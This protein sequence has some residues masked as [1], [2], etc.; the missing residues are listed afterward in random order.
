M[1]NVI[2]KDMYHKLLNCVVYHDNNLIY[3]VILSFR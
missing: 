1:I 3:E 2:N